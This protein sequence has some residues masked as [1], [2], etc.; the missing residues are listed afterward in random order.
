MQTSKFVDVTRTFLPVDPNAF[1]QTLATSSQQ[2]AP[3]RAIPV[4]A[5][6]GYNF[7][8]TPY[9]YKSYFGTAQKVNISALAAN[10]DA[11]FNFQNKEYENVLVALTDTG[12]WIKKG[13]E[14]GAW[15]N[16]VPMSASEV[17]ALH[18]EWTFC[19]IS[20]ILY[21]YRQGF[22][23]FQKIES[24]VANGVTIT[25]VVPTFLNMTAQTGI[26]RAAGRLAF[27]DSADS[28][29]WSNLDDFGDF[30][31]SLET[32]AGNSTFADINGRIVTIK[33]HGTGFIIYCTKSIIFV[34]Q[35]IDNVYQWKPEVILSTCGISYPG[36]VADASPD[37][38]HFAYTQEGVKKIENGKQDTIITEVTDYLKEYIKPVYLKVLQGRY[39][40]LELIDDSYVVGAIQLTEEIIPATTFT[41]PGFDNPIS[42]SIPSTNNS[43]CNAIAG[44]TGGKFEQGQPAVPPG[45]KAPGTFY[46]PIWTAYLSNGMVHNADNITFGAQPCPT[47]DPFGV[48]AG[49]CPEFGA[50]KT[51]DI[52]QDTT[53][54]QS[55]TG[56]QAY[57]DGNWTIERF[58]QTQ[59][60]LWDAQDKALAAVVAKIT[61][62]AKVVTRTT[63]SA[64]PNNSFARNECTIGRYITKFSG[65]KFGWSPCEFWLTRYAIGAADLIRV[66][67][68]QSVSAGT[69]PVY[70]PWNYAGAEYPSPGAAIAAACAGNIGFTCAGYDAGSLRTGVRIYASNGIDTTSEW[71]YGKI[72][73]VES[74]INGLHTSRTEISSGAYNNTE[75][76]SAYNKALNV[77]IAPIA[78]TAFVRITGW[79]YNKVGG[80]TGIVPAVACASPSTYPSAGGPNKAGVSAPPI[81]KK[82][83]SICGTPYIAATVGVAGS[84]LTPLLWPSLPNLVLPPASFL[85][86]KG[87]I[88]P[89][90]PT[91][92]GG[93]VYDMEL[94]KWGKY[95]LEYKK[96]LDYS[97][98]NSSA[99]GI[100]PYNTFGI[101]SGALTGDGKISLFDQYPTD[102]YISYGKIGFSRLTKTKME[103]A[104]VHFKTPSTGYIKIETALEGKALSA[105]LVREEAFTSVM[106]HSIYGMYPGQWYNIEVGG[107][108]DIQYLEYRGFNNGRR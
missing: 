23:S 32:L 85:L 58:I 41:F 54:K 74:I 76:M 100:V 40:V 24:S 84:A 79:K 51:T 97:P 89:F 86:Q 75:T 14:V 96:L 106:N 46:T 5:Y 11:V 108:F 93:L 105:G 52:T 59:T 107:I 44:L 77:D 22:A 91:F 63:N 103:E 98:V 26:F 20:N 99:N 48:E 8:P 42:A 16:S 49:Q 57:V 4:M 53:N 95:R 101:I 80:G 21:A 69:D 38:L 90:Y 17:P 33:A 102:S 9:G 60:A 31:P 43:L 34:R 55:S 45:D 81:S 6:K 13:S 50:L 78:D 88:A 66:K 62:R 70:G 47:V 39:L 28:T 92:S 10:V 71:F 25:S 64:V 18:L 7:L 56:A 19:V 12:I 73:G 65:A 104:H 1:P 30:V 3:E 67:A 29:A 15:V 87:S 27:W 2:E 94:K 36:Q 61:S 37:T 82:N 72:N 68:N 35:N 83:G